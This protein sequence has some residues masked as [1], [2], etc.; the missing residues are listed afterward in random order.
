MHSGPVLSW[1]GT[2]ADRWETAVF[3][4][5]GDAGFIATGYQSGM[6]PLPYTLSYKLDVRW[7]FLHS[8]LIVQSRGDGWRRRL[9]LRREREGT[10]SWATAAEGDNGLPDPGASEDLEAELAGALDCD[11]GLSPLTNLM[12]IRRNGLHAAPGVC[13]IVVVWVAV[14]NLSLH[15]APQRYEHLSSHPDGAVVRFTALDSGFTAD[16][17]VDGNGVVVTYPGL[18][19]R[20]R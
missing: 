17:E 18:A 2:D 13:D 3:E 11:L 19:R 1:L 6:D 7:G 8:H 12:P 9:F 5:A 16:L 14:P 15:A 4:S 10:W 20:A